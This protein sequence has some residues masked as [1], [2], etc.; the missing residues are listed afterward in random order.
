MILNDLMSSLNNLLNDLM[1][2]LNDLGE[3]N[4]YLCFA[5]MKIS[6]NPRARAWRVERGV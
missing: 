3:A 2:S 1:A 6:E 5:A 4:L